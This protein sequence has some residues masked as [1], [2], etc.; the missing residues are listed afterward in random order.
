MPGIVDQYRMQ[1]SED[2]STA[3]NPTMETQTSL[4]PLI[5]LQEY[6]NDAAAIGDAMYG[7]GEEGLGSEGPEPMGEMPEMGAMPE[8]EMEEQPGSARELLRQR[9]VQR[10]QRSDT[11]QQKAMEFS[12]KPKGVGGY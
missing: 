10:A 5:Q 9:A 11:F 6:Y 2:M 8:G 7:P 1:L 3:E 12:Q 4:T